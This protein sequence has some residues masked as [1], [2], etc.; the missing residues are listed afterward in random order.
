V[1]K[2]KEP[3]KLKVVVSYTLDPDVIDRVSEMADS[4]G[5]S[6]SFF[7]NIQL[8]VA[9]GMVDERTNNFLNRGK[10]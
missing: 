7:A 8:R 2:E 6:A 9:L 5:L 4:L 3:D 1:S 10:Q